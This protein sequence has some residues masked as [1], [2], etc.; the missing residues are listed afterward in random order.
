MPVSTLGGEMIV[1]WPTF[2]PSTSVIA[3]KRPGS[4]IPM[5]SP[6]SRALGR[7]TWLRA[8]FGRQPNRMAATATRPAM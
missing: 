6:T 4:N 5:S 1:L 3:F 7:S 8:M 2:T